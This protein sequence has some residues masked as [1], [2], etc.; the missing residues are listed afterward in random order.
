MQFRVI[1]QNSEI[2]RVLLSKYGV[3]TTWNVS[4]S[5]PNW[6]ACCSSSFTPSSIM[7]SISIFCRL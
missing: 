6:W 5:F 2:S 7:Y 1:T 4:N 3:L